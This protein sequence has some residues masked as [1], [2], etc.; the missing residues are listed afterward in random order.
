MHLQCLSVHWSLFALVVGEGTK[1]TKKKLF[2]FPSIAFHLDVANVVQPYIITYFHKIRHFS[3]Q[4]WLTH[5]I[6][7]RA[8]KDRN[9]ADCIH[10]SHIAILPAIRLPFKLNEEKKTKEKMIKKRKQTV[11]LEKNRWAKAN[12]NKQN[13]LKLFERALCVHRKCFRVFVCVSEK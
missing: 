4:F 8:S 6:A 9:F 12:E 5:C 11:G 13:R 3:G 2:A 10:F 1:T 7:H